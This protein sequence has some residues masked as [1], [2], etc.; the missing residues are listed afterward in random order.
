M[1]EGSEAVGRCGHWFLGGKRARVRVT[2]GLAAYL[3]SKRKW[4]KMEKEKV[5]IDRGERMRRKPFG[6]V[7]TYCTTKGNLKP[8]LQLTVT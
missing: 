3:E 7:G 6:K 2:S 5:D 4:K 8:Q 1:A